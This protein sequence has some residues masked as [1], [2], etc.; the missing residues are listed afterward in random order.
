MLNLKK[1]NTFLC[2][3]VF[4]LLSA[5]CFDNSDYQIEYAFAQKMQLDTIKVLSA[6]SDNRAIIED[7]HFQDLVPTMESYSKEYYSEFNAVLTE[8]QLID[9]ERERLKYSYEK[10]QQSSLFSAL[11]PNAI[12]IASLSYFSGVNLRSFIA[13][14]G[15]AISS[16]SSYLTVRDQMEL[17]Y[18]QSNWDL[19][20]DQKRMLD[21]LENKLYGYIC[22]IG[23]SLG[24]SRSDIIS[25]NDLT[26]FVKACQIKEPN[27]RYT[28][29]KRMEKRLYRLPDYW[30]EMAKA[31]YDLYDYE[32]AIEN[33][34]KYELEYI[35][36]F[37]HDNDYA[38]AM[39]IKADCLLKIREY[40]DTLVSELDQIINEILKNI[41]LE[42][43]IRYL[44]CANL[45]QKI[46]DYTNNITYAEQAFDCLYNVTSYMIQEYKQATKDYLNLTF[47]TEGLKI[48]DARIEAASSVLA[49]E[50]AIR[51]NSAPTWF[52]D[53][54][55]YY[56]RRVENAQK[57]VDRL[58]AERKAFEESKFYTLPPLDNNLIIAY[59]LYDKY[60]EMLGKKTSREYISINNMLND[61]IFYSASRFELFEES[62]DSIMYQDCDGDCLYIS[63]VVKDLTKLDS[64]EFSLYY[65]VSAEIFINDNTFTCNGYAII[66][67][68][69][70]IDSVYLSSY[71]F[72][73]DD[74]AVDFPKKTQINPIQ[75][76]FICD[77]FPELN[78]S[79]K[80]FVTE[81]L[82]SEI[83]SKL[84]YSDNV[85][86]KIGDFMSKIPILGTFF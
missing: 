66:E 74:F 31:A 80:V 82:Q 63:F 25:K 30:R 77:L 10:N 54:R 36:I 84:K 8:L 1:I 4:V 76:N 9:I 33:L 24:I 42:D 85:D 83:E 65:P 27:T 6:E 21:S 44:F 37:F 43:W 60:A 67:N 59:G 48:I 11:V 46:Y 61:A 19:N 13:V 16:Y 75:V 34:E 64:E 49:N 58:N 38:Q 81:K 62:S 28:E 41:N 51:K 20:D 3:F 29:L 15:T 79:G 52:S 56:D 7:L 55:D 12:S 53:N 39:M 71:I 86:D 5:F 35:P 23:M 47:L 78:P 17:E 73:P 45:Y 70:T 18:L 2:F 72:M 69:G 68:Y 32:E 40:D 22:D 50:K 57:E 14:A 26:T